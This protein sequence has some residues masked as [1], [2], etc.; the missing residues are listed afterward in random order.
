MIPGGQIRVW[1]VREEG[2]GD[3]PPMTP[4]S[5]IRH[6]PVTP[7]GVPPVTPF[8]FEAVTPTPA[9]KR[10]IACG[11]DEDEGAQGEI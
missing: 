11:E 3:L 9:A 6:A 8:G 1:N 7:H 4:K 10:R 5:S 2:G